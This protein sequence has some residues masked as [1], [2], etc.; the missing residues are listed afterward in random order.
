MR[1]CAL[2]TM[3]SAVCLACQAHTP[4]ACSNKRKTCTLMVQ[5][6][7]QMLFGGDRFGSGCVEV[8]FQVTLQARQCPRWAA[9]TGRP[10]M[11]SS[12]IEGLKS[13]AT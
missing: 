11:S 8:I 5:P 10:A 9:R 2:H 4:A 13:K 12:A 6:T 1:W 3:F 7:Q